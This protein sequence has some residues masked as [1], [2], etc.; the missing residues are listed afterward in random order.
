MRSKFPWIGV[1]FAV[2]LC[3]G[4]AYAGPAE[5]R[6]AADALFQEGRELLKGGRPVEA[7]PK[8]AASQ[9]LDPRPGRLLALG[10]CYE[11]SGET[12]SAWATFREAES[13]ARAGKDERR[14]EEAARR[15][16]ELEPKLARLLVEVGP[17]ARVAGLEVRRNGKRVE[18][19]VWGAAVPVDPGEQ[20]IEAG[21]PGKKGW[22]EKV[23]VE[24]KAGVTRVKVPVL[25]EEGKVVVKE[26]GEGAG[27]S[28]TVIAVGAAVGVVGV[29]GVG[30][31]VGFLV[32]ASGVRA[33]AD[34]TIADADL[35]QGDCPGGNVQDA[36][37]CTKLK[38]QLG[39][40]DTFTNVGTGVL[41]A[42]GVVATGTLVYA[43]WPRKRSAKAG[44]DVVPVVAPSF[45]GVVAAGRF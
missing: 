1:A 37:A 29:V 34:Q 30:A 40:L 11:T 41:I 5:D 33:D 44:L 36:A 35:V 23:V 17:E 9:K 6:A 31:G 10:D 8:F 14:M 21:A 42:G 24:G 43:L 32:A 38:E 2:N 12:A 39:S 13:M 22:A 25:G 4:P 20:R 18:A 27:K 26:E 16:G 28:I 15:A 45:A 7:C 19:E 3:L